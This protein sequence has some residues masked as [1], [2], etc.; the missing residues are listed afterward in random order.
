MRRGN[1]KIDRKPKVFLI[2]KPKDIHVIPKQIYINNVDFTLFKILTINLKAL[3]MTLLV[4]HFL[5]FLISLPT[6]EWSI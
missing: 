2:L 5:D 3:K 1:E 4:L 6:H